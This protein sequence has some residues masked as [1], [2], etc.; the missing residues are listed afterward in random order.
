MEKILLEEG[1]AQKGPPYDYNKYA[2][3]A[4]ILMDKDLKKNLIDCESDILAKINTDHFPVILKVKM[5]LE[6]KP[7]DKEEATNKYYKP[8]AEDREKHN[9]DFKE[10][11]EETGEELNFEEITKAIKKAAEEN[12]KEVDMEKKTD[13]ISENTWDN[14]QTNIK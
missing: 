12:L 2:Q 4:Y 1:E 7:T 5:A 10:R 3:C 6:T 11:T 8:N 9:E 14:S 13:Y